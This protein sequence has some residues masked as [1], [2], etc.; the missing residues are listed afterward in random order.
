MRS[1]FVMLAGENVQS[2]SARIT[3]V[4]ADQTERPRELAVFEHPAFDISRT[5]ELVEL[6]LEGS[7]RANTGRR[8]VCLRLE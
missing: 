4:R 8:D 6:R 5:G 1:L 7:W 2:G 3:L